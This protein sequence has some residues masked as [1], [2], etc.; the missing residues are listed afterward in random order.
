[1]AK[2]KGRTIDYDRA[3]TLLDTNFVQAES[4]LLLQ[5]PPSAHEVIRGVCEVL[6][7]SPTQAYREVLLGCIVAR[8]QDK[9]INI[10]QPYVRQGPNAFNGRTLDEKVINPFLQEKR[11][12]CSRGPYLSVFRRSVQFDEETRTGVRDKTGYDAFLVGITYI[13]RIS[14]DS[15]LLS[16]LRY[17]LYKFA[18]LREKATIPVSRLQRIS[19]EQ[20]DKLISSLLDTQSGG[21]F[22]VILV[23]ATFR[24]IKEFFD[25]D[26]DILYQGINVADAAIGAGGDITIL[27][28]TGQTLMAVEVTE[29]PVDGSRV[30]AIF[31]TK[32]APTGIADYLFF[33]KDS[34]S[35]SREAREQAHRCF[36]QGHEVNFVEIKNWIVILLATMG[37]QGR[38]IFN[39]VL[40]ELLDVPEIPKSLKVRWNELIDEITM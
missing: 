21:R 37:K 7:E 38:D 10:R 26:W 34:Q 25:M 31:R 24:A 40:L 32:I 1:M 4:D 19:L 2:P 16:I 9:S 39:R 36:S 8:I 18:E 3:R 13:E 30:V 22:P 27:G 5:S 28:E 29:R 6:F 17:I 33:V 14:Q 35:I 11:I 12:P 20:Y 23:V 15:E